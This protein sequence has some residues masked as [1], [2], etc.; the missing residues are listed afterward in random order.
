M[1]KRCSVLFVL[2]GLM[3]MFSFVAIP[4]LGAVTLDSKGD[5][6]LG[7]YLR[8][9]TGVRMEDSI[10]PTTSGPLAS[11]NKA[12]SFSMVRTELFLDFSAKFTDELRFNGTARGWYEAV[13]GLDTGVNQ[14]P[15][16]LDT[17][18][19]P[20]ANP[21]EMGFDFREYYVTYSPGNF[22]VKAGSQQIA[23]G[24]ADALRL[25]DVI[26]PLDLS[27]YWSF[28]AWEEIR[29]PLTMLDVVYNVP[30]NKHNLRFEAVWVP[31]DFR[32][33]QFAA[34]GGNWSLY[35]GGF[36]LPDFVGT[37][38]FNQMN[39]DLPSNDL[40][41]G[42]GGVRIRGKFGEWDTSL[43]GYYQRDQ[44][45]VATLDPQAALNPQLYPFKWD[46]PHIMNIG[47]TFNMYSSM[48]ETVFRGETAYV[49]G[50]PYG[51]NLGSN[52][53][54]GFAPVTNY[55]ES[56]TFAFMLG[57]DKN[58]MIP[59][60]NRTKSFYFS[61]QWFNK[62]A[63]SLDSDKYL[64]FMGDN[65]AK[66]FQTVASL[67][68]NTEYFEGKIIP[69]VLGVHFFTSGSGFFDGNITFKPTYT[70]SIAAG[71]L[72]IWGNDNQA[73]L[74]FGPIKRD[75]QLYLTAKWSF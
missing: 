5:Y 6:E 48:F 37:A 12:W 75:D 70:F 72:K 67:M 65:D 23:W 2:M 58:V 46:F 27:W 57:F 55:G 68:I 25:A 69:Q 66:T 15:R 53:G 22:V 47:G 42:Q 13:Y 63:L 52:D 51:T 44:I 34:P 59:A 41:N 50:Q 20:H 33:H 14:Y 45:G 71:I 39:N 21:M 8:N 24:E 36:G 18:P 40:R 38:V 7:G 35:S 56:D 60:L 73:G 4:N 32:P 11:G 10:N 26:N 49:I 31:A 16:D 62:W 29:I 1:K 74:Y 43:F 61:G 64:T 3:V 19:G 30:E 17:V 28:P 54:K 9:T